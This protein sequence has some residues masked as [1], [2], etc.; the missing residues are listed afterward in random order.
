[1]QKRRNSS[2]LAGELRVF[3]IKPSMCDIR[4]KCAFVRRVR[5]TRGMCFASMAVLPSC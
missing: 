4:K 3:C 2:A 5:E 1:M